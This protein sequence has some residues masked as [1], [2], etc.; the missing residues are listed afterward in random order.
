MRA[1]E[2]ER[3]GLDRLLARPPAERVLGASPFR[4]AWLPGAAGA[5][6]IERGGDAVV[7][8][9]ERGE[10]AR[11]GAPPSPTALAIDERGLVW[12]GGT[13]SP[14]I[15]AYRIDPAA[16]R[17]ERVA[18]HRL[19]GAWTARSLV[20]GGPGWLFAADERTGRVIALAIEPAANGNGGD[21]DGDGD[22]RGARVVAEREV[23]R[24]GAPIGL[25][26]S[27]RHLVAACLHDRALVAWPLGEDGGP[28]A[29]A[30]LWIR[31][32]GPLWSVAVVSGPDRDLLVAG[33]VEDHPLERQGGGF[34]Y[35]DSYLFV[36]ALEDGRA[37]RRAAVNLSAV[38]VVTPRWV[39][40]EPRPG[41][42]LVRTAGH[43]SATLAR[44]WIPE[45]GPPGSIETRPF[46]PG[47]TDW[48]PG[49]PGRPALAASGLLDAW[50][51]DRG[52]PERPARIAAPEPP[53]AP[54][55]SLESRVGEALLFTTLMAPWGSSEGK[56]SRFTCETCHFEAKTDGRTHHTGRGA[57]HATTRPLRG[58]LE[59]RPHFSRAL[60]RTT[61][62]MVHAE[63]RVANR[64]NG[65][66]PWFDVTAAD[67]PWIEAIEGA[68]A[69]LT[70]AFLRRSLV[71]FLGDLGFDGNQ[72]V[73]GRDRFE[74]AERDGAA[75]FR[76]RCAD[77]HRPRI[78]TD[79][80]ASEIPFERWEE[81]VMSPAGPIVWASPERRITGVE[82][83][84]HPEGARTPS[85]RRLHAK[86]PY[87]TTGAARSLDE[88]L[89]R[90][91]WDGARFFHDGAPAGAARLSAEER[92]ALVAFL[93]LL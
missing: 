73:R 76:D 64:W 4:V 60:D 43:G 28:A 79:E 2:E 72:A 63:F 83:R 84:V 47:T 87:F 91:G 59:N 75:L 34:G 11:A 92:A 69:R 32:D 6:G 26:R 77:C 71:A 90:A 31:H 42:A 37:R 20:H 10:R 88:V 16:A 74:P 25:A 49:P 85:L 1:F 82:P 17:I 80:P 23:G 33:G 78:I 27:R 46:W 67:V 24:C 62:R 15:A 36:Y 21:G 22:G 45:A 56:R 93:E 7:L 9:D 51:V 35:I 13:G 8:L 12:V 38:D 41:G 53:G 52:G 65:R 55:R 58:L 3:R 5:V 40:I 68:P 50:L 44:M 81:L 66:D 54:T 29:G 89:A 61:T 14:E 86:W 70:A 18:A 19:S 57:I 48:S 39:H 30:P